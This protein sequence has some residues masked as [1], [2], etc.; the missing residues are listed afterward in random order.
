MWL[1]I[2]LVVL[3]AAALFLAVRKLVRDKKRGKCA[4]G[5]ET[6]DGCRR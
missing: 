2:L 5:C 3:I 1:D 6:C 4:C